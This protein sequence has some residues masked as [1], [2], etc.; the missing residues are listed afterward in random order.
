[1]RRPRSPGRT[2]KEG[3]QKREKT[4]TKKKENKSK[5]GSPKESKQ[6]VSQKP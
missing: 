5:G 6:L 3:K 4:K 1:M 2:T